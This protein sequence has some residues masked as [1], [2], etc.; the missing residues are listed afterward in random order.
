MMFSYRLFLVLSAAVVGANVFA[1]NREDRARAALRRMYGNPRA[2][3]MEVFF[4]F[5]EYGRTVSVD[6]RDP[7]RKDLQALEAAFDLQEQQEKRVNEDRQ[8]V[9]EIKLP[10]IPSYYHNFGT[11]IRIVEET[12]LPSGQ[13]K[14]EEW[15]VIGDG[16]GPGS[17][18]IKR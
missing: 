4:T 9:Q 7:M 18:T 3:S 15:T 2:Y 10:S 13:V 1:M 17:T 12:R 6:R 5:T 11:D 8:V 16:T 14:R